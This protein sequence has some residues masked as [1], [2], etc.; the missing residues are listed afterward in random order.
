MTSFWQ[1]NWTTM[2]GA[3]LLLLA[4]GISMCSWTPGCFLSAAPKPQTVQTKQRTGEPT[5]LRA[6]TTNRIQH[7]D[8]A[9]FDREV[10]RSEMPV[11]VDFYADWC[12]PCRALSPVLEEVAREN[13]GAKI[14]KVNVDENPELALQY[15]VDSI[16]RLIVFKGGRPVAQH[17]GM[18]NKSYLKALLA[19]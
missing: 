18:A 11:L 6:E 19:R 15:R 12:G 7:A 10:L 17:S 4:G 1:Q 16:P 8:A 2:G 14:V 3:A 13:P 9:D 5:M